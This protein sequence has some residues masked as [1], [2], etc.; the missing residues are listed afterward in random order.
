[1]EVVNLA[2]RERSSS[3]RANKTNLSERVNVVAVI[4]IWCTVDLTILNHRQ[5]YIASHLL[6]KIYD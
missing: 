6:C 4:C 1:M 2:P 5:V 3:S